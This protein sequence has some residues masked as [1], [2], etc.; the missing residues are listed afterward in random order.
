MVWVYHLGMLNDYEVLQKCSQQDQN[1]YVNHVTA[2]FRQRR[3]FSYS[4][5][6]RSNASKASSP[7][8]L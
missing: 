6:T 1:G 5:A 2:F 3:K 7:I 8:L 4:T